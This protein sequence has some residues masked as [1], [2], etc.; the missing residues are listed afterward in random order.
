MASRFQCEVKTQPCERLR[1]ERR[2]RKLQRTRE[3]SETAPQIGGAE[4]SITDFRAKADLIPATPGI[5]VRV[6]V[7]KAW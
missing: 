2:G 1:A 7:R 5:C 6:L 4:R 3:P